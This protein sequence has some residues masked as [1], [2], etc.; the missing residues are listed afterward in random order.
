MTSAAREPDSPDH[1]PDPGDA[2]P[3]YRHEW[4]DDELSAL[5]VA[6]NRSHLHIA[7]ICTPATEFDIEDHLAKLAPRLGMARGRVRDYCYI[8]LMLRRM[9]DFRD[10]AMARGVLPFNFLDSVAAST[11]AV[12]DEHIAAV[13]MDLLDY[14]TPAKDGV[15]LPG[16]RTFN[17]EIARIVDSHEPLARPIDEDEAAEERARRE[18]IDIVTDSPSGMGYLNAVLDKDRMAE[19]EEIITAVRNR[20]IDLDGAC[21][22]ADAF[23]H[24]IRGDTQAKTVM[25]LYRSVDGGPAYLEGCGWLDGFATEEWTARAT[26]MR[27]SADSRVGGYTPSDAQRARVRGR[28]GCCRFPGC[29]VPAHKCDIDHIQPYDHENP[30]A[31]GPTDT[32]NLHCLC[33]THHNLKTSRLWDVTKL[34]DDT[35]IWSS[36][37]SGETYVSVP[38]GPLKG[39]GRQ[40]FD[41]AITR[42]TATLREHNLR[43][44]SEEAEAEE[45]DRE[46][47]EREKRLAEEA[48]ARDDAF[49]EANLRRRDR[50]HAADMRGYEEANAAWFDAQAEGWPTA[51]DDPQPPA[52]PLPHPDIPF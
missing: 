24:A 42:L 36:R 47:R 52:R 30:G 32:A 27:M 40:T 1:D 2:D 34:A 19:V 28:D 23:M 26:H 37:T 6:Q 38:E 45:A 21:T 18:D 25:N 46:A 20:R 33:R 29:G 17:R 41:E 5:V 12:S 35:E 4:A 13:E 11:V 50:I 48:K 7:E 15:A 10:R 8:G 3:V 39:C 16:I 22:W 49:R 44:L 31:G 9:P 51:D 14:L 43:R